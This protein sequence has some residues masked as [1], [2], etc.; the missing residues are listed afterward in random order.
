MTSAEIAELC[1]ALMLA[2]FGASWP[3]NLI[4]SI[5]TKSTKGKSL[6]FLIL[7]DVGYVIGIAG[8]L[9]S[10]GTSWTSILAF[11]VYIFNFVFVTADFIMYFVNKACEKR[12]KELASNE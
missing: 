5:K 3:I 4:K 9:I 10:W 8:K 6:V 7:I 1:V 12:A 2:C 11:S